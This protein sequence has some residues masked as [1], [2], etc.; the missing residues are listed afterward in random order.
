[1]KFSEAQREEKR[2][3][4]IGKNNPRWN[5]GVSEYP[6]HVEMKRNRLLKLAESKNKCEICGE[7]AFCVHHL[8]GSFDNHSLDNLVVLCHRCHL[9]LHNDRFERNHSLKQKTSKY[10]RE[11]GLTLEGMAAKYG[12]SATRYFYL[13]RIGE[14]H[15]FIEKQEKKIPEK[16]ACK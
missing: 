6:N 9:V 16:A 14:L 10:I 11:Y 2:K 3:S 1:M 7:D 12:G 4:F 13:H 15:R 8:D 5:G